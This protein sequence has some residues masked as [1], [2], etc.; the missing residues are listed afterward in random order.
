MIEIEKP[1]IEIV[2]M[3]DDNRY[4]KFVIEPLERGFG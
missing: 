3:S 2:E 1:K 4:G